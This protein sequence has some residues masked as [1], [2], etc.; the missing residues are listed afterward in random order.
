MLQKAFS[1]PNIRIDD[2]TV[3][4]LKSEVN[5]LPVASVAA[6]RKKY[7]AGVIA[8][9]NQL[10]VRPFCAEPE[11]CALVRVAAQQGRFPRRAKTA[12]A[13][14]SMQPTGWR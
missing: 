6:C 11:A 8:I 2:L 5:K 13:Y 14:S 1:S 4:L 9:L 12:C 3:D 7:M 10:R